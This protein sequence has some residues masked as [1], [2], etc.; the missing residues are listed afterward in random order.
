MTRN[1]KIE[2]LVQLE[3]S[4]ISCDPD[5]AR[6]N[7]EGYLRHGLRGFENM[8]DSELDAELEVFEEILGGPGGCT[9]EEYLTA[10]WIVPEGA[11]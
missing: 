3:L 10:H 2:Q 5:C 7:L 6:D 4:F 9:L 8:D 11:A 1:E